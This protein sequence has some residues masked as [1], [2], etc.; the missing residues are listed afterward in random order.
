MARD[1]GNFLYWSAAL[2]AVVIAAWAALDFAYGLDEG[3]PIFPVTALL[4]AVG[5]WLVGRCCRGVLHR[6]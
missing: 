4:C 1:V 2:F 6:R 3:E 5:I